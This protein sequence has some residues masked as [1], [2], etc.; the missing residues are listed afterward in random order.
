M[1]QMLTKPGSSSRTVQRFFGPWLTQHYIYIASQMEGIAIS[2]IVL[3]TVYSQGSFSRIFEA[4]VLQWLG[5]VSFSIY[6][7]HPVFLHAVYVEWLPGSV[8]DMPD[9]IFN[10]DRNIWWDKY[11]IY[12]ALT[13]TWA[14][15]SH[16]LLEAN[17]MRLGRFVSKTLFPRCALVS[18]PATAEVTGDVPPYEYER[19]LP[20][21]HKLE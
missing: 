4:S 12:S 13:L 7:W 3:L 18:P 9:P 19:V 21:G 8:I 6:L 11:L 14:M 5:E 1:A 10:T 16:W 20:E 15:V 17:I 2:A